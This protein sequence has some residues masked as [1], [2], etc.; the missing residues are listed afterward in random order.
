MDFFQI[1]NISKQDLFPIILQCKIIYTDEEELL[2]HEGEEPKGY[3]ALIQGSIITK[4]SF[5]SKCIN[6]IF[7]EEILR[8]YNINSKEIEWLNNKI[9]FKISEENYEKKLETIRNNYIFENKN[10][11]NIIKNNNSNSKS[12]LKS[13]LFRK[14]MVN[15]AIKN[16]YEKIN[17]KNQKNLFKYD[18]DKKTHLYIGSKMDRIKDFLF[19]G[20]VDLFNCYMENSPQVHLSSCFTYSKS[21]TNNILLYFDNL[22]LKDLKKKVIFNNKQKIKFLKEKIPII[23]DISSIELE[24]FISTIKLIFI[25][26]NSKKEIDV[27]N[28]TFYL[29][30]KGSCH[31]FINTRI[32]YDSGDFLCLDNLDYP[33]KTF[34][35]ISKSENLV[36]FE[37]NLS[38]LLPEIQ[39]SIKIFTKYIYKNQVFL[40]TK[41]KFNS[42]F[43]NKKMNSENNLISGYK[44]KIA[45][46]KYLNKPNKFFHKS[47]IVH[48][49]S[50]QYQVMN[51]KSNKRLYN[52]IDT[53]KVNENAK[54]IVFRKTKIKS[55]SLHNNINT[56]RSEKQTKN[57]SILSNIESKKYFYKSEKNQK[58]RR[59]L[60]IK[61]VSSRKFLNE[62]KTEEKYKFST[63]KNEENYKACSHIQVP[64]LF[65]KLD[66]KIQNKRYFSL[67]FDLNSSNNLNKKANLETKREINEK[68]EKNKKNKKNKN[69]I[70]PYKAGKNKM[71]YFFEKI[72]ERKKANNK[73]FVIVNYSK[74]IDKFNKGILRLTNQS[75]MEEN[76]KCN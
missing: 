70:Y 18:N 57:I 21:G 64:S 32:I 12:L 29:I 50:D 40:R 15:T 26:C 43:Y 46:Y 35:F 65:S 37:I 27:P 4:I 69:Y 25:E 24:F 62:E 71:V 2:F 47:E 56:N 72:S 7:K 14:E 51:I 9:F 28:N 58:I 59:D 76:K 49:L 68:S 23:K 54:H 34:T 41:E 20:G 16:S 17:Y 3:Y 63:I 42:K 19:F 75:I 48:L 38:S 53:M 5:N 73:N 22:I 52:K 55:F 74:I 30:Y 67:K 13:S 44:T 45:N 61:E 60:G 39:K 31:N 6:S 11:Y 66:E 8:E 36:L 10:V 33:I 1:N